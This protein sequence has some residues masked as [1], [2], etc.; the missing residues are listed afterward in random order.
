MRQREKSLT[1]KVDVSINSQRT[2]VRSC[3]RVKLARL[4]SRLK[5]PQAGRVSSCSESAL[6]DYKK[7]FQLTCG[8]T[9]SIFRDGG[10][11]RFCG[12]C[13][14]PKST[15]NASHQTPKWPIWW[16]VRSPGNV[17]TMALRSYRRSGCSFPFS[18]GTRIPCGDGVGPAPTQN[19]ASA[20]K[21]EGHFTVVVFETWGKTCK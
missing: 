4:A 15:V 1:F 19:F 6:A 18:S 17:S 10:T 12:I 8:E 7:P 13:T 21:K 20:K 11:L 3:V 9:P 16:I 14:W 5:D 2:A